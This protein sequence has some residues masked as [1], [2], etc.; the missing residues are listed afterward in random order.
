MS[1]KSNKTNSRI[2]TNTALLFIMSVVFGVITFTTASQIYKASNNFQPVS[3]APGLCFDETKTEGSFVRDN[4][5]ICLTMADEDGNPLPVTDDNEYALFFYD[6]LTLTSLVRSGDHIALI[7][8][9]GSM[10]TLAGLVTTFV[11]WNHNKAK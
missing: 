6:R 7:I 10:L 4:S 9:I 3:D 2:K 8:A 1:T 11:Y 5:Y